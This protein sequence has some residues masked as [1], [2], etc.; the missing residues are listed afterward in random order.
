MFTDFDFDNVGVVKGTLKGVKLW[1]K[2]LLKLF[3]GA[4]PALL[5]TETLYFHLYDASHNLSRY[6]AKEKEGNGTRYADIVSLS[7]PVSLYACVSVGLC[8]SVSLSWLPK[9]SFA[10]R[11]LGDKKEIW[12][13]G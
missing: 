11:R 5:I 10:K 8:L 6:Y 1:W 4:S 3:E 12:V 9:Y 7:V 13:Y 2:I